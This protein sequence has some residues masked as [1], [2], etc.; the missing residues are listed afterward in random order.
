MGF[1]SQTMFNLLSFQVPLYAVSPFKLQLIFSY[2]PLSIL[3]LKLGCQPIII[4]GHHPLVHLAIK[5]RVQTHYYFGSQ[6]PYPS[7][8]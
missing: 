4:L 6:S 8:N 2:K 3:Q 1:W 7:Y 5:I